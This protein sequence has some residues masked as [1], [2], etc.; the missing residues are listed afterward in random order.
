MAL[1]LVIEDNLASLE[2]VTYLLQ[3]FG[4]TPVTA[5]DGVTGLAVVR[6]QAVD[7]ILCDL[8]LPDLDGYQV[9]KA[10]KGDPALASIPILA[11]T[12]YAMVGDRDKI[13]AAGFDGYIAKPIQ[14]ETFV[15]QLEGFLR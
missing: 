3:A 4:H 10:I 14:P 12:A 11:V 8:H 13:L 7:L 1:I 5:V 15:K 2:L 9:M 6:Q